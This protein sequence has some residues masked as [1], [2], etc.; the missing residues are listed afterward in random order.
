MELSGAISAL[1]GLAQKS[2][3]RIFRLLIKAGPVGIP[4]GE[5]AHTLKVPKNTMSSHLSILAQAGLVTSRRE[6]RYIIY[7]VDLNGVRGLLTFLM[8]DCCQGE[9]E[10]CAPLIE[11]ILPMCPHG[12]APGV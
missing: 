9:L 3:L 2:R 7:S 1:S 11:N 10:V 5:I 8:S 12:S 6:G 4:A